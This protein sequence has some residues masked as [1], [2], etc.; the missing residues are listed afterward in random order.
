MTMVDGK[1]L[2]EDGRFTTIDAAKA[3]RD[4]KRAVKRLFKA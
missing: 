2:Y 4:L 1:I 3:E